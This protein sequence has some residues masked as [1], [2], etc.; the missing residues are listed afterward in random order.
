ML[1]SKRSHGRALGTKHSNVDLLGA[2]MV[3][4]EDK[5]PVSEPEP[6]KTKLEK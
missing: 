3:I 2:K 6:K 5:K 1:G 4:H